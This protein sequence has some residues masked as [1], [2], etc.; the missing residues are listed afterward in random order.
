MT[1]PTD[2][3]TVENRQAVDAGQG[4]E[5]SFA[6]SQND[7]VVKE[8]AEA[9]KT[10][11]DAVKAALNAGE[12]QGQQSD[13]QSDS[14]IRAGNEGEA[15]NGG[16]Q[17]SDESEPA[18]LSPKGRE[19]WKRL[20]ADRDQWAGKAQQFEK[21]AGAY[22]QITGMVQRSGLDAQEID[23]AFSIASLVKRDPA[24][25]LKELSGVV[26]SLRRIVGEVL[27]PDIQALVDDGSMT[28]TAARQFARSRFDAEHARRNA[29][30]LAQQQR[31]QQE[32]QQANAQRNEQAQLVAKT[33]SVLTDWENNW[34]AADP[35]FSFKQPL[36]RARVIELV[37][38]RG[39]PMSIDA[40]VA[41]ANEAR[42]SINSQLRGVLPR[43]RQ[44]IRTVTGGEANGAVPA[45]PRTPLEAVNAALGE[46]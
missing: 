26:D 2:T 7:V 23:S 21:K 29:T 43:N 37:Q 33:G 24:A 46:K 28:E 8:Q 3:S 16:E 12:D 5:A 41:L 10:G 22:D 18:N 4:S 35:D 13:E 9:P 1:Q 15:T 38:E 42:D 45:R 32:R 25:A 44:T 36:V 19:N 39:R 40:A 31:E 6:D 34:R 20:Q 14:T 30:Q 11:L 17:S 27:P